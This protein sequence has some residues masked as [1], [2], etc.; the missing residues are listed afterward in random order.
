[1]VATC[2]AFPSV[3]TTI[4]PYF[5][6]QRASIGMGVMQG[7]H[8]ASL[9][10]SNLKSARFPLGL[11]RPITELSEDVHMGGGRVLGLIPAG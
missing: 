7:C 9:L 6:S 11:R 3:L 10:D 8:T 2:A 4:S 1:M 5:C